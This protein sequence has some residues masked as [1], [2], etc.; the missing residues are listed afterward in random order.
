MK[1]IEV[2]D[3]QILLDIVLQHYGT[4]EAMGEIMANNPG[5]ENEPSAVMD[6]GRELGPFYPDI[7]LRA[8]LRVSVDDDSRLVKKTVVGKINGS[9]TTYMETPWRERSRK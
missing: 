3:K 8:G 6:A 9:V 4:A 1:T 2:Q 5:L 7:K